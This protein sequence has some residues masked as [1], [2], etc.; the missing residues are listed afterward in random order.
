MGGTWDATN[1]TSAKVAVV[2]PIDLDHTALLG[3][4]VAEIAAEKAGI[5]KAGSKA[6]LAAQP[7]AAA[8]VLLARCTEVGAEVRREG[9]E[10]GLID[11]SVAVGGQV[12]RLETAEGPLGDLVLPLF[13]RHQAQNCLLYT[14][15][16][17]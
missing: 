16:C 4:T 15:R 10:F 6:V 8:Q 7:P 14:S 17:V 3:D 1:I 12:L 5:I 2:T 11:R 13:G 9:I